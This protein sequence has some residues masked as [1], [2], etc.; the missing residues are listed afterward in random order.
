MEPS[1]LP[2]DDKLRDPRMEILLFSYKYERKSIEDKI[3]Y[4]NS[5]KDEFPEEYEKYLKYRKKIEKKTPNL[6]QHY[7]DFLDGKIDD[8]NI[9]YFVE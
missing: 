2:Y 1:F 9:E 3:N 7:Y 8:I 6:K 5:V 4:E